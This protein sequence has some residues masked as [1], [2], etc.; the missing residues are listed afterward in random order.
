MTMATPLVDRLLARQARMEVLRAPFEAVWTEIAERII[1]RKAMF[2]K[3]NQP[4][5]SKGQRITSK[6]FD[7]VPSLALDRYASAVHSLVVPRNQIWHRMRAAIEELNNDMRVKR[8][9]EQVNRILFAARYA[10]NFDNQVHEGFYDHGAFATQAL[11][12]GDTGSKILYKA[13]PLHQLYLMENAYGVVDITHRKYPITARN[14]MREFDPAKLPDAIKRAAGETPEREFTFLEVCQPNGERDFERDDHRGMAFSQ[15]VVSMDHRALVEESGYHEFPYAVSRYS[16]APGEVYGRGPAEI[17]LPD[18]KM[19]NEMNKTTMQAAQLKMLPPLLA[20]RQG[21]IDAVRMTP[22]A[23]NYGGVN[24]SG[25]ALIQPLQVGGDVGIG[26]ELMDQKRKVVQD[27]FWNTLFQILVDSPQMTATEAML[28]AQEKGVLLAPTAS[29]I[30]SEFLAQIIKCEL[31]HLARNGLLPEAPEELVEAGAGYE[32]E[33]ES[34]MARARSAERGIGM[35]RTWEQLTPLAAA[36]G[37]QGARVFRRF[38]P[39]KSAQIM[40]EVNG[41]PAEAMYSDDELAAMDEQEAAQAQ[42]AELLQAAPV[43]AS[44]A[45]DLA[46]A[47]ALMV[48]QPTSSPVPA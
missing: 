36:M 41:Y 18:V 25:Q 39:D 3:R 40:A 6:I 22:A 26:I 4:N 17:V 1:P 44:A 9:L 11:Y 12:V 27:A 2:T 24:A 5:E 31:Y 32:L 42:A 29:R 14:A 23:V 34:P 38:N 7:A 20:Q 8:Y 28:R 10:G 35:L 43:A 19:L 33:Y 47:Q 30:E 46:Q 37:E 16:C 45:K 21:V 15:F 13:V 48:A